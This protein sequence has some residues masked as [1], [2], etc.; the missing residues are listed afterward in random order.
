MAVDLYSPAVL[1]RV[2]DTLDRPQTFLLTTF[3]PEI[4]ISQSEE[5][6]FDVMNDKP[7]LTPF[8]SPM[9]E[10]QIVQSLGY[11]TS[12]F[13]PAYAKDKR[14]FE[15]NKQFRRRAGQQ[16]G[17]AVD[18]AANLQASLAMETVDQLNMLNRRL[19]WMAA[20]VLR[21]GTVTITGEKYPTTVV[22]FGRDAALTVTLAGTARWNDAAPVPLDNLETWAGLIR[23]K[24]GANAVDVV[25]PENV[26]TVFRKNADVKDLIDNENRDARTRMNIGPSA[27][28]EGATYKGTIGSFNIWVYY[29][30]YVD[31][32]GATQKF[33]PD[34]YVI[35]AS[36]QM[37]GVRHFGA[38]R[39][40]EVG[41][42]AR[43]F[44][45]KSWVMP[46]PAVRFLLMQSAPLVVPYRV[47][48]TLAAQVM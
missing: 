22:N 46:D 28:F 10:G 43:E 7:R 37:M 41:F 47:N 19:E 16:I 9:V 13:K 15:P 36:S 6:W 8:V 29:D 40:E 35:M 24:S 12:S 3:F 38:I 32:A 17:A 2:V 5:I 11:T 44:F 1:N 48:A 4:S 39:D 27:A 21:T 18:P 20:E 45:Q 25:M 34:N 31:E 30:T 14:V 26:W 33:L 42:Q 23:T